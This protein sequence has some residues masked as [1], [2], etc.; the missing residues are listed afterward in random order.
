MGLSSG[1]IGGRPRR[2]DVGMLGFD[3]NDVG[4]GL[5]IYPEMN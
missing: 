1:E 3:G 5:A 2:F 4:Q